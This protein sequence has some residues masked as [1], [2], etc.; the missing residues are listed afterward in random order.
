MS[1]STTRSLLFIASFGACASAAFSQI[2]LKNSQYTYLEGEARGSGGRI[3][4]PRV[5]PVIGAPFASIAEAGSSSSIVSGLIENYGTGAMIEIE[6]TQKRSASFSHFGGAISFINFHLDAPFTYE[7]S[8]SY[9]NATEG[10]ASLSVSLVQSPTN[11]KKYRGQKDLYVAGILVVG[12]LPNNQTGSLTG[13]LE[14]GDYS[15]NIGTLQ[16][17][18]TTGLAGTTSAGTVTLIIGEVPCYADCDPSTGPGVLD[19]FDFLC[20]QQ[21]FV[22]GDPSACDC[23]TSSGPGVCDVF[24]FLCFQ[25]AFVAGCP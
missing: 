9:P 14:A 2:T 16:Y 10:H 7:L 25:D 18:H 1:T 8:G 4:A 11:V 21:R 6:F 20:F 23:D 17:A 5:D 24:D 12:D 3:V 22:G 15:F 19:I 13:T